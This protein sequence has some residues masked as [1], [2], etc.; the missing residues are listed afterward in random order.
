MNAA[1]ESFP[2]EAPEN[3]S[4]MQEHVFR[5]ESARTPFS[6]VDALGWTIGEEGYS[7]TSVE[8]LLSWIPQR[9]LYQVGMTDAET[10]LEQFVAQGAGVCQDFAHLYLTL[11]RRWGWPARYVSGYFFSAEASADRIEAEAMHAWVEVYREQ[12][13]WIALD[14]T[15]GTYA[16]DR[17][18]PVAY[19]RDYSDVS[20]VRGMLQGGTQ[21]VQTSR[22]Q[23][24][25]RQIQQ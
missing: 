23:M 17:Y 1:V 9:F 10:T 20:P 21:Q 19:G 22:L 12:S 24:V 13:G 18:I 5:A 15:A 2:I 16:D 4:P 11:L 7:W 25:Q 8:A 3:L 14:A 6:G